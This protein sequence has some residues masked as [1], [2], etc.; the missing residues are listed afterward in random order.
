MNHSWVIIG[1]AIVIILLAALFL[2]RKRKQTS[3]R[4]S[5][6]GLGIAL[7]ALGILFGEDRLVGY[8]FIGVG[9]LL[10]IISA[11]KNKK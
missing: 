5:L 11:I 10:S 7:I 8:S 3:Q 2:A 1:I 9:V 6:L 4:N